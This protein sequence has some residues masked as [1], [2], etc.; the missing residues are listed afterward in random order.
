MV[1]T[2]VQGQWQLPYCLQCWPT[3]KLIL[4]LVSGSTINRNPVTGKQNTK[5]LSKAL[6]GFC[7]ASLS[8][9]IHLHG[10]KYDD[11]HVGDHND[12]DVYMQR[13]HRFLPLE[14]S[15]Y[16]SGLKDIW[17][18]VIPSKRPYLFIWISS[19]DMIL[20]LLRVLPLEV[21]GLAANPLACCSLAASPL[22]PPHSDRPIFFWLSPGRGG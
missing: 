3:S 5:W 1:V 16:I 20:R 2:L 7:S 14:E 18:V 9:H 4:S 22:V 17:Y 12:G 8:L 21:Q 13:Y 6:V 10:D 11:G 19:S 15:L